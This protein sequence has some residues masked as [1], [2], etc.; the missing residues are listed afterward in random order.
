MDDALRE[1]LRVLMDEGWERWAQFDREV[2]RRSFHPFVAADYERVLDALLP[3]RAPGLRFLEWGSATG[4]V[5]IMADLLG[6]DSY[7]IELDGRLVRIAR[8]LAERYESGARFAEGSFM[9]SGYRWRPSHGDGRLGTIGIGESAYP[10]LGRVLEDFDVV[11]AYPWT[12][13]EPMMMDLMKTY[14]RSGGRLM[15]HGNEGVVV[16]TL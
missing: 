6:F 13:E 1:R 16:H 5:T 12:G 7:G 11:Y 4:V 8:E 2:R 9:P 10:K 14:G 3:L 15:L